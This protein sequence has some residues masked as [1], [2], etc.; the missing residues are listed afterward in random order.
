MPLTTDNEML[1]KAALNNAS[2]KEKSSDSDKSN[3]EV[4][5]KVLLSKA[6]D[7]KTISNKIS[8]DAWIR[9]VMQTARTWDDL[10]N[11]IKLTGIDEVDEDHK[12]MAIYA[13]EI[14]NLVSIFE[15]DGF[16]LSYI[17][18][19]NEFLEKFYNYTVTH[20]KREEAMMKPFGFSWFERHQDQHGEILSQM[21]SMI[22]DCNA[23]RATISLNLKVAVLE[24]VM[25]H[26]NKVD[27]HDF[28]LKNWRPLFLNA[29][30]LED[31]SHLIKKTGV[32]ILDKEHLDLAAIVIDFDQMLMETSPNAALSISQIEALKSYFAAFLK[33]A[34]AH[35]A[36]EEKFICEYD[37][38]GMEEQRE[39]HANF[40]VM[41]E[42]YNEACLTG[43]IEKL[44]GFKLRIIEWW[45]HHINQ[46]DYRSFGLG[47]WAAKMLEKARVWDDVSGFVKLMGIEEIDEYHRKMT[48]YA[49]EF[50]HIIDRTIKKPNDSSLAKEATVIFEK[51]Y[52]CAE[53]HFSMEEKIVKERYPKF[54]DGQQEQH[55]IFLEQLRTYMGDLEASRVQLT[56]K[57]KVGILNWWVNHINVT[58][59]NT[60]IANKERV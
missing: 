4:S 22:D 6:D 27:Y 60:F 16:S 20:F 48:E 17:K 56:Q 15:E 43:D 46:V 57:M 7:N 54:L 28:S 30:K 19:Q 34:L 10:A 9:W 11:V 12:K 21:R 39:Q 51:L 1:K 45:I 35:F 23:G 37:L 3:R 49:L 58:D 40:I 42:E 18:R 8:D 29:T 14:N 25:V 13:L 59:Y 33:G 32:E 50:S 5:E 52:K 26:I 41:L 53:E 38:K 47:N 55:V 36:D 24:W 2:L 44:K 31:V